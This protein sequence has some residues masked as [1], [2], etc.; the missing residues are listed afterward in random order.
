MLL[1]AG[2]LLWIVG[3][4][5]ADGGALPWDMQSLEQTPD[6]TWGT[7]TNGVQQVFYG[8]VPYQGHPTRVFAYYAEPTNVSAP[9][10]AVVLVHGAGRGANADWALYWADRGYVALSMDLN[11]DG[12]EGRLPD[13]GPALVDRF[14]SFTAD[15]IDQQWMY[16]AVAAVVRGC[17]LLATR[18]RVDAARIGVH[19][20]SLGGCV[21]AIAASIDHRP[22]AAAL[23]FGA[24]YLQEGSFVA[25]LIQSLDC[26][27]RRLWARYFDASSYLSGSTCRWLFASGALDPFFP[28]TGF[29]RS[30][31]LVPGGAE[32]SVPPSRLH[33]YVHAIPGADTE[34]NRFMDHWLKGGV[35]LPKL[36][37]IV[38]QGTSVS[39]WFTSPLSV[40][41]A[42]LN[43][44][45][46]LGPWNQRTWQSVPAQIAEGNIRAFLPP[47]R[48]LSFFLSLA[49]SGGAVVTTP[50]V[51]DWGEEQ[52]LVLRIT[53]HIS[54]STGQLEMEGLKPWGHRIVLSSTTDLCRWSDWGT[55]YTSDTRF[56]FILEAPAAT[57]VTFYRVR[58]IDW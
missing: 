34:I 35:P 11:G 37:P 52:E 27:S 22:R 19:G 45:T 7:V 57:G 46:N 23:V 2:V 21:A 13:G 43:Y 15:A 50:I 26:E 58:D 6:V 8:S 42:A 48:P 10:P 56:G 16:H 3:A 1:V 28:P 40:E 5:A 25:D 54:Q 53:A 9:F 36:G 32:L 39:A 55:N 33:G 4:L 24:G 17:S 47:D 38:R 14:R 51:A 31:A 49:D 18:P 20:L 41:Q 44:T 30:A 12:P 29:I